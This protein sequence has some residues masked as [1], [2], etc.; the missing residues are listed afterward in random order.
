MRLL[1]ISNYFPPVH[2]GGYATYCER[3]VSG[4]VDRGVA[5]AILTTSRTPLG[6]RAGRRANPPG[7]IL[8]RKLDWTDTPGWSAPLWNT[9]RNRRAAKRLIRE[10]RPDLIA[11]FGLDGVGCDLL[12]CSLESGLPVVV[13]VGDTWLSQAFADLARFDR[14]TGLLTARKESPAVAAAR[15]AARGLLR[16]LSVPMPGCL[17]VCPRV[18]AISTYLIEE[19]RAAG[20]P[21]PA[22]SRV[23]RPPL[24]DE[25]FAASPERGSPGAPLRALFLSR[26]ELLKGP[27][28]A[29]QALGLARGR[30]VD[31]R[32]TVGGFRLHE[33]RARLEDL[34][35]ELGVAEHVSWLDSLDPTDVLRTYLAHDVLLFPSRITEGL[36][37]VIVEAAACGLPT[38]GTGLGG[39]GEV[40]REGVTGFRFPPG[41]AESLAGLLGRLAGDPALIERLGAGARRMAQEFRS[42]PVMDEVEAFYREIAR[43]PAG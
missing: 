1:V 34:A 19:L 3:V 32:L 26:V 22:D 18:H 31:V 24:P 37:Q 4:L 30:G 16:V 11:V 36:G 25:Y 14:L 28:T 6:R 8:H 29:I 43:R 2:E 9:V 41:D 38:L 20:A 27:D 21:A 7:I 35:K 39:S 5:V 12:L 17:P 13:A 40:I 23:I 42:G 10:T 15:S 33:T